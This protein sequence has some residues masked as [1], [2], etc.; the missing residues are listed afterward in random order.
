[1][2]RWH[3]YGEFQ[4][5]VNTGGQITFVRL[6]GVIG[7]FV[8]VLACINFMNLA[9]AR[10]GRR[11]KEVGIRKAIGSGR[12][13]LVAQFLGES[14]LVALLAFGLSLLLV[15]L[16]LPAFSAVAGKSLAIPVAEPAF[17]AMGLGFSVLTGLLAGSYP[18]LYLSS[19][20]PVR[21][22]KGPFRAGRSAVISR[23][24]LVVLQFAVS[25]ALLIGVILVYRQ[26]QF[27]KDRPVGYHQ[28][29]LI[30]VET[31]T[32]DIH[33]RMEVVRAELKATGAVV[34]MSGSLNP[35]TDVSFVQG[36][37][38]WN[39][40]AGQD[41]GFATVWVDHEFGRTIGWQL[42]AGRD[43]SRAFPHGFDVPGAQ[44]GG[45]KGNGPA[46]SDRHPRA[47]SLAER[48]GGLPGGWGD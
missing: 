48:S 45:R 5:G 20:R 38:E 25:I 9:T 13:Q 19:F 21:V 27:A 33:N 41:I 29:G 32:A 26:V 34:E 17:W 23:Q 1:M 46:K 39:G 16:A 3:L 28:E 10:S 6:F 4:D 44:R 11:A 22:L 40:P 18:A 37:Y 12:G 8:L 14:L 47:G 2:S 24:A 30:M 7:G 42:K 36:G 35:L 15:Q 31:P 43:F